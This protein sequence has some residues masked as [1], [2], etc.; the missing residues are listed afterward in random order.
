MLTNVYN[1]GAGV[2]HLLF[3][4]DGQFILFLPYTIIT[5]YTLILRAR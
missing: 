2:G 5:E 4:G 1:H 3:L